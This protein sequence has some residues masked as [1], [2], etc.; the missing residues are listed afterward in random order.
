MPTNR[1]LIEAYVEAFN[2][3]DMPRLREI[4]APDAKIWG[5]LGHGG[6]DFA[7]PVWSEL[8]H[9]MSTRLEIADMVVE[10]DRAAVRYRETGR[11]VGT[12]RGLAGETPTGKTYEL[13]AMEWFEFADGRITARWGAR[14]SAAIARQVLG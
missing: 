13:V 5:V 1:D 12:F 6:L 3:F 9:G 10:G 2:A 4:F 8:H 11:F 14:D 7:A